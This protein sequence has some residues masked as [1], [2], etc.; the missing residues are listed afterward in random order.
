MA[1][2]S[3]LS[4]HLEMLPGDFPELFE[5]SLPA[6]QHF[7]LLSADPVAAQVGA[8]HHA[9]LTALKVSSEEI[10]GSLPGGASSVLRQL[11]AI[12]GAERGSLRPHM[13][14]LLKAVGATTAP[15]VFLTEQLAG[16]TQ[17]PAAQVRLGCC[18]RVNFCAMYVSCVW[19]TVGEVQELGCRMERAGIV[20]V[21]SMKCASL[22]HMWRRCGSCSFLMRAGWR[23]GSLTRPQTRPPAF[24]GCC[25]RCW[26]WL[27][28]PKGLR[29]ALSWQP[30]RPSRH[31]SSPAAAMPKAP[32]QAWQLHH[33]LPQNVPQ[34]IVL[35]TESNIALTE[36]RNNSSAP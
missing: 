26:P 11:V 23:Q 17:S 24:T 25:Q 35:S 31:P 36:L 10:L 20:G 28:C 18:R 29:G 4:L 7:S 34:K 22:L 6:D 8:Q 19:R 2:D 13:V 21:L 5:G 15:S 1:P 33:A 12:P 30:C 32:S 3:A 9:L 27:L 16:F 14:A